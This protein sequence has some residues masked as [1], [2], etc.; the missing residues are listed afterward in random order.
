MATGVLVIGVGS[1]TKNLQNYLKGSKAYIAGGKF[2][3]ETDTLD[4]EGK[5]VRTEDHDHVT[6][7][8]LVEVLPH[9]TGENIII[10]VDE[11]D[12]TITLALIASS[13]I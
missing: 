5:V 10:S 4:T 1:G 12:P 13:L 8:K 6:Q 3:E 2:G 9:F 11:S 7:Q